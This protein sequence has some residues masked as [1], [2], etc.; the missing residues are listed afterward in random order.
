MAISI[1]IARTALLLLGLTLTASGCVIEPTEGF[2]DHDHHRWWHEHT[3]HDCHDRD[4]HC[5]DHDRD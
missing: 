4:E 2:Y 1:P 5:R 3:W